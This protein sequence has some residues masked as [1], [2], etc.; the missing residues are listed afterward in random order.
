MSHDSSHVAHSLFP[1]KRCTGPIGFP[2][3]ASKSGALNSTLKVAF[4]PFTL[5][6]AHDETKNSSCLAANCRTQS[7]E[8][9]QI[10]EALWY[11]GDDVAFHVEN[12][13]RKPKL[14]RK[15]NFTVSCY[16]EKILMDWDWII[17]EFF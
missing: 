16:D 4:I 13:D 10:G 2:M 14:K 9:K 12:G 1:R 6:R 7:V 17:P 15:E 11:R 3:L 5:G 8:E